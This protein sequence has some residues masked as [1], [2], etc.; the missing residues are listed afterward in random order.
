[1]TARTVA[2]CGVPLPTAVAA[3]LSA[4]GDYHGGAIENAMRLL[5][6]A[7]STAKANSL[8][9]AQQ[10]QRLV[11]EYTA[12]KKRIPGLGHRYH[13]ADPRTARIFQL[14]E[15]LQ[16]ARDHVVMFKQ[17]QQEFARQKQKDLPINVDGAI[18]AVLSDMDFP[19]ELG[20]GFFMLGRAAG[21]IAHV[22]EEMTTQRP[23]RTIVPADAVYTG[24]TEQDLEK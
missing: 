11:T 12:Q 5:Q 13:T 17:I 9:L 4:I 15:E 8:T 18:A 2:S 21:L 7:V 10:A 24:P 20:K 16:L 19:P 14:A 1:M 23:V 22:Y 6:Q 3:G